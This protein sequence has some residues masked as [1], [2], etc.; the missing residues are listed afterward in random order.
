MTIFLASCGLQSSD[1]PLE[2]WADPHIPTQIQIT[3]TTQCI[4]NSLLSY[5]FTKIDITRPLMYL[6][7]I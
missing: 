3:S 4:T 1:E 6:P 7:L 5:F 2:M